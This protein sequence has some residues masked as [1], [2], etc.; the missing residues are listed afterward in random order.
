MRPSIQ[1]LSDLTWWDRT[2]DLYAQLQLAAAEVLATRGDKRGL[3]TLVA[4]C[5]EA[6]ESPPRTSL[7]RIL[8]NPKRLNDFD[9]VKEWFDSNRHV[10]RC[11]KHALWKEQ[12]DHGE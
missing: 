10:L 4:L 11:T 6:E 5:G 1:S 3:E 2:L 8:D 9:S 12:G 7:E